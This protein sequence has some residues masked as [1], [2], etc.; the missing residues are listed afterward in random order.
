MPLYPEAIQACTVWWGHAGIAET[1][2]P[3]EQSAS[4]LEGIL[5]AE[6]ADAVGIAHHVAAPGAVQ[7]LPSTKTNSPNCHE[8]LAGTQF[9]AGCMRSHAQLGCV[10]DAWRRKAG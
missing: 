5:T 9:G 3:L 1:P 6:A 10:W 8:S 2:E 7:H 4:H